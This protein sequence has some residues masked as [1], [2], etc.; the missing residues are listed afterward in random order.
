ML[1]L[2]AFDVFENTTHPMIV[3]ENVADVGG[4]VN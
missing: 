2:V 3:H 1:Q 4:S